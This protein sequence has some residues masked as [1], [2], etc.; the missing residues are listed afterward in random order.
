M[1]ALK[2]VPGLLLASTQQTITKSW[3]TA[4]R[5]ADGD[6]I[7]LDPANGNFVGKL[8]RAYGHLQHECSQP[9]A[10]LIN[11]KWDN[12]SDDRVVN[13][14]AK[15]CIANLDAAAKSAGLYY[16]FVYLNDATGS[17]DVFKH[18]GGGKS[19]P[20]MRAIA[21]SYGMFLY[22]TIS[23]NHVSLTSVAADPKKVFQ[24]LMPGGFKIFPK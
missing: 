19:L 3:L 4:A 18:Y 10:Y 14:F 8:N 6:A 20:R 24:I 2:N 11:A 13:E 21:K 16:P 5:A 22:I 7:D 1:P 9:T 15:K 12:P 17:E 23:S